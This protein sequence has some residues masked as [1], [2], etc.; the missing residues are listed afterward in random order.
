MPFEEREWRW[1]LWSFLC[2]L[3]WTSP[4]IYHNGSYFIRPEMYSDPPS[5]VPGLPDD[6]TLPPSMKANHIEGMRQTRYFLEHALALA[7]LSRRVEDC[8]IRPGPV[9]PAQAAEICSELDAQENK[10]DFY[11]LLGGST[12]QGRDSNSSFTP[13][14]NSVSGSA[15]VRGGRHSRSS[16]SYSSNKHQVSL[17]E[18]LRAQHD[19]LSLELGLIRFKL[20]RHEALYVMRDATSSSPLRMMCMDACMDAC[21]LVLSRSR[22]LGSLDI[23]HHVDVNTA[24][25]EQMRSTA[26]ARL[27]SDANGES[28]RSSFPGIFRRVIQPASSAALVGQVLIHASQSVD[29]LNVLIPDTNK[30]GKPP[31]AGGLKLS[32][33]VGVIN[34][35]SGGN[36]TAV[37]DYHAHTE[38]LTET[39]GPHHHY[40]ASGSNGG[41]G[42]SWTGRTGREKVGILQ[43]HVNSVSLILLLY[44][45]APHSR[46]LSGGEQPSLTLEACS[47]DSKKTNVKSKVIDSE[48]V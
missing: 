23:P 11:Q 15:S 19:H 44:P 10:Q 33:G 17:Q 26:A 28:C 16:S 37:S 35:L 31:V 45:T 36:P 40:L 18:A 24:G 25:A 27:T 38:R 48:S 29:G 4:S 3:D 46:H 8:I 1:Q 39:F 9:S 6:G 20:F 7:N 2:V 41:R 13:T 21:T 5:K 32:R 12:G 43:W 22:N 34:S 30:K 42:V 14:N 47:S